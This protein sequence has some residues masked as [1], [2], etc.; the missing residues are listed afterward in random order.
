[1]KIIPIHNRGYFFSLDALIA[2]LIILGVVL[3]IKGPSVNVTH[4][5]RVHED[6]LAALSS[7]KI[8]DLNNSYANDLRLNGTIKNL[9]QSVLEQIGEFYANSSNEGTLLAQSILSDLNLSENIGIY[10]NNDTIANSSKLDYDQAENLVTARQIISGI[11]QGDSVKGYSSR[12]FLFSDKVVDYIYF[13]GYVGDGNIT[14]NLGENVIGANLEGAFSGNFSLYINNNF[15][16]NYSPIKDIPFKIS[17][18]NYTSNFIYGNNSLEFRSNQNLYISGGFIRVIYNTTIQPAFNEKDYFPGIDGFINLYQGFYVP[19]NINTMDICIHYNSSYDVFL[20]IGNFT[21]MHENSSGVPKKTCFDDKFLSEIPEFGTPLGSYSK[22][23]NKTIP[24]RLGLFNVSYFVNMTVPSDAVSVV[25]VSGSMCDCS[26]TNFFCRYDQSLCENPAWCGTGSV[27]N[28]G[29]YEAKNATK[30]FIDIV[31]NTTGNRVSLVAYNNTAPNQSYYPL[32]SN[33]VSLKSKI[34]TWKAVGG[35]CICCGINKAHTELSNNSNS[36]RF[37]SI[38]VMSDGDPNRE[39][40]GPGQQP[41]SGDWDGDGLN[42][43]ARDDAIL[44]AC[45]AYNNSGIKVYAI[46]FG[47]AANMTVMSR[48]ASCGHGNSYS[49]GINNITYLYQQV[50][51]DLLVASYQEQTVTGTASASTKLFPDSYIHINYQLNPPYGLLV[52]S[53]SSNFSNNISQGSFNIPSDSVPYEARVVS[54]SGA[55]WSSKAEVYNEISSSWTSIFNLGDY[56]LNF[57]DL[58]DPYFINIPKDKLVYGNNTVKIQTG[59]SPGNLSGGSPYN[60]VIYSVV[61]N[62]SA[63]SNITTYAEGCTWN[64]EFEDGSISDIKVP[65]N[66]AGTNSCSYKSSNISYDNRDAIQIAIYDLLSELDLNSNGK[67]ESKFT[68]SDLS[69]DTTEIEGIPFTWESEVQVRAWR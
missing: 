65:S 26:N 50:A 54:Y 62:L 11:Q 63:Y 49:G 28:G 34:D 30:V 58:G 8:G 57:T 15:S 6:L 13:G 35:T 42:D 31:L 4:D 24:L 16:G 46:G 7:I 36:S 55:K 52:S 41:N 1:M 9:N 66:Y 39:C 2:L 60:K 47:P 64:L 33:N 59:L 3:F 10:F 29:I 67:I 48:I 44:A 12:A 37:R 5:Q 53:E 51:Q 27:C 14:I 43:T 45:Q 68:E 25:D 21:L 23:V 32:S 20:N 17:L 69:L 61:K 56:G 22:L 40:D 38:V 18:A 19:G